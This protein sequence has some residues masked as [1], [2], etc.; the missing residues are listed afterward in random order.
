M[1]THEGILAGVVWGALRAA[2]AGTVYEVAT[3]EGDRPCVVV[4]LPSG[5]EL[6]VTVTETRAEP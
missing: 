4:R 6:V 1:T 2:L 3:P 5:A